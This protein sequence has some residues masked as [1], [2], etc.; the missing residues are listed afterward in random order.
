[1][2]A[3]FFDMDGVLSRGHYMFKIWRYFYGQGFMSRENLKSLLSVVNAYLLRKMDYRDFTK[4][5]IEIAAHCVAG[6]DRERIKNSIDDFLAKKGLSL[7]PY[8]MELVQ[9]FKRNGYRTIIISG[10]TTELLEAYN[11]QIGADEVHGTVLEVKDGAFTGNVELNMSFKESKQS[12]MDSMKGIDMEKSFGFGDTDQDLAML[13]KVGH[14]VALNPTKP[15]KKMAAQRGW[16]VLTK[17]DDVVARVA[18][19]ME[20]RA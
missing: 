13:E 5:T 2:K 18:E 9:L 19:M 10:S 11:K 8:S 1:M 7:F 6:C 4:S 3:A 14:P 12:A 17:K 20:A 16:A 15:L